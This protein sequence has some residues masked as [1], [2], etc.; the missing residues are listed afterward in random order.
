VAIDSEPEPILRRVEEA[1]YLIKAYDGVRYVRLIRDIERV[2]VRP[3]PG[4]LG[5][6]EDS[7]HACVLDRGFVLAET[8]LPELIAATIVHEATH[9]R[10]HR[11]GIGYEEKLRTRIEAVCFRRELAFASKLPNG[12]QARERAERSLTFYASEDYW[13]NAA[14]G[15]RFD[16]DQGDLLR[17]LGAPNWLV[18]TALALR[19]LLLRVSRLTQAVR[20][21]IQRR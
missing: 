16:K 4:A 7:L 6:F 11:R 9:A 20:R 1:L 14:F 15:E 21:S 17:S 12:E 10:L 19:A 8:S 3:I 5:S 13:T 18:R 2:W